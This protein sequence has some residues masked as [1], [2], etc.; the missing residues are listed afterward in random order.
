MQFLGSDNSILDIVV[1]SGAVQIDG[2][3]L[4]QKSMPEAG[5]TVVLIPDQHRDRTELFRNVATDLNGKY[6]MRGVAPGDYKLFAW[7]SI[8]PFGWFDPDILR[9]EE[10]K[11]K[12]IHVSES[13]NQSVDLRVI[14]SQ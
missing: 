14:V 11:G 3:A 5:V 12:A 9:R 2:S 4:D 7:E 1:S 13:S 10:S 6:T 8:D